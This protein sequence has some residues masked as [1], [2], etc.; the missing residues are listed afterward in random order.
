VPT[1]EEPAK[2]GDERATMPTAP[3]PRRWQ[4]S[5]VVALA[6]AVVGVIGQ[7]ASDASV[8]GDR[9]GAGG[10]VAKSLLSTCEFPAAGA[11]QVTTGITAGF[12]ATA[13]AGEPVVLSDVTGLVVLP[14]PT[15]A[16]L[17]DT[18]AQT[19]EGVAYLSLRVSYQDSLRETQARLTIPAQPLPE[20]GELRVEAV[21]ET[22]PVTTDGPGPMAFAFGAPSFALAL[23]SGDG[24]IGEQSLTPVTCTVLPDQDTALAT[25]DIAADP[26]A[27]PSKS[28]LPPPEGASPTGPGAERDAVITAGICGEEIP[29]DAFKTRDAYYDVVVTATVPKLNDTMTFG[30][31]GYLG[32]ETW[33]WVRR[34][35]NKPVYCSGIKG[36]LWLPPTRGD[37]VTFRFVPVSSLV[38]VLPVGQAEGA[39][40]P[41][42]YVFTGSAVTVMKLDEVTTGG[43]PVDAGPTCQSL[44]VTIALQSRPGEWNAADGGFMEA[45]FDLPAFSGCGVTEPLDWLFTNLVSGPGNHFRID[46]GPVRIC[47]GEQQPPVCPTPAGGR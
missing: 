14:E 17:R 30:P 10:P 38:T 19:V 22:D 45:D 23:R 31:P 24:P 15:V 42:T 33:I 36:T 41:K 12:P 39:V 21:A 13:P 8:D 4:R 40:D 35:N 9:S 27:V 5:I 43:A 29:P 20:T 18:G 16:A 6:I 7:V 34:E 2:T 1:G 11:R 25:V 47:E 32:A 28:S 37:F 46:F 3:T 26:D 44:P